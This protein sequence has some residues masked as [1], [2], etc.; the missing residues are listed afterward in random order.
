MGAYNAK[1]SN[2]VDRQNRRTSS[3]PCPHSKS[4]SLFKLTSS[5]SRSHWHSSS[6][7]KLS[8]LNHYNYNQSNGFMQDSLDIYFVRQ[9]AR[10]LRV[11][12]D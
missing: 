9:I 11:R 5:L 4:K 8:C 6:T 10:S 3:V 7:A 2:N 1:P 12:I